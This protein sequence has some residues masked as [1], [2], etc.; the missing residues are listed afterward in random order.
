[1]LTG[2]KALLQLL[3]LDIELLPRCPQ[4]LSGGFELGSLFLQ[5]LGLI[6]ELLLNRFLL[7]TQSRQRC[8]IVCLSGI[9]LLLELAMLALELR[10][11][12]FQFGRLLFE[13]ATCALELATQLVELVAKSVALLPELDEGFL[14]V[15]LPG[16]LERLDLG[17]SVVQLFEQF[18]PLVL[19][20]SGNATALVLRFQ[21]LLFE[22]FQIGFQP[23]VFFVEALALEGQILGLGFEP[24]FL[25]LQLA[26]RLTDFVLSG[27]QLVRSLL[28]LFLLLLEFMD[29]SL[30]F[31]VNAKL[32]GLELRLA[33]IQFCAQAVELFDLNLKDLRLAVQF[34]ANEIF[35]FGDFLANGFELFGQLGF[36]EL[37]L[38]ALRAEQLVR[39]ATMLAHSASNSVAPNRLGA[40]R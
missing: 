16:R 24:I 40:G 17:P 33:A 27:V 28:Q 38:F 39:A 7:L 5:L 36:D 29:E 20:L 13:L 8:L 9:A 21:P 15:G 2:R 18:G 19:Q 22:R 10:S 23:V 11:G 6:V 4:L 12:L 30:I 25:L 31:L 14:G 35:A 1:L 32:L 34:L 26:L 37:E 3:T